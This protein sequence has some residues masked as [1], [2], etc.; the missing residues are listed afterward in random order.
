MWGSLSL[1]WGAC[2]LLTNSMGKHVEK[3]PIPA[4]CH[5]PTLAAQS[6]A[7][8]LVTSAKHKAVEGTEKT[9]AGFGGCLPTLLLAHT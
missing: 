6:P 2:L 4:K 7:A 9:S 8:S 5:R 3:P 1:D